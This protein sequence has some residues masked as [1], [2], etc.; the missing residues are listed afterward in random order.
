MLDQLVVRVLAL[1][2]L[3]VRGSLVLSRSWFEN[4]PLTLLIFGDL[5]DIVGILCLG[6][7]HLQ[8]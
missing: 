3:W 1:G 4:F 7:W 2:R 5:V 8:I 6:Q